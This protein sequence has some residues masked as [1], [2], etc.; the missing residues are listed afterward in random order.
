[1]RSKQ[2]QIAN[3]VFMAI[4]V[5][6]LLIGAPTPQSQAQTCEAVSGA[7]CYYVSPTGKDTNPGTFSAPLF[8]PQEA[9]RLV[10]PGD[11]VYLRGGT[12]TSSNSYT[13]ANVWDVPASGVHYIFINL[14]HVGIPAWASRTGKSETW[15]VASGQPG[16]PIT[17]KAYLG[18]RV[19]VQNAGHIRIGS[20]AKE[21]A[22]YNVEGITL[23]GDNILI[24]GGSKG[25]NDT[26][27]NQVHDIGIRNNEVF[28]YGA[29]AANNIGLITVNRG[30]WGGPYNI[31]IENNILHD[32]YHK[33]TAGSEACTDPGPLYWADPAIDMQHF[34][35]IATLSCESYIQPYGTCGGNGLLT[36]RNNVIYNVPQAFYFK[37]P[38]KGPIVISGNTL[39]NAWNL[40][41][42]GSSWAASNIEFTR[43]VT[44]GIGSGARLGG[45]GGDRSTPVYLV[46]GRNLNMQY[47]T[48]IDID[49]IANFFVFGSNHTIK[50]NLIFGL[51]GLKTGAVWETPSYLSRSCEL[52]CDNLDIALSDLH[53]GNDFNDNCF[54]TP[55][56]NFLAVRREVPQPTGTKMDYL[57]LAQAKTIFGFETRSLNI[58][59][60]NKNNVF[61]D[62]T[63]GDY[64]L[65]PGHACAAMGAYSSSLPPN[66]TA[67]PIITNVAVDT[68]VAGT[69]T[70]TWNTNEAADSRVEFGSTA[71]YG[72][73]STLST[74]KVTSH[75]VVL[76]NLASGGYHFRVKSHDV[77]GNLGIS[78]DAL[79][80]LSAPP[81]APLH[82]KV[83]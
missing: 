80:T 55:S 49:S 7:K 48:F 2:K 83:Q 58:V 35:G 52:Y 62:P 72:T 25:P 68:A 26:A 17:I 20:L 60:T 10:Q 51:K 56:S 21:N 74:P 40:G 33:C 79:F 81:S 11:F 28:N 22:Y 15:G 37:N 41:G 29:K 8:R 82:L 38:T 78:G 65:K 71:L 3:I 1:M 54:I 75:T 64:R 43:N 34:G 19:H 18:E 14:G 32:L 23:E 9:L 24:S 69:V 59:E 53:T 42:G 73:V 16:Q 31:T 36:I 13:Y 6:F 77:E 57:D 63:N 4:S 66:P 12:Y 47:N 27:I 61:I 70:M 44:W 46:S 5:V 45:F 67:P 39:Y 76:V 50:N 30:D